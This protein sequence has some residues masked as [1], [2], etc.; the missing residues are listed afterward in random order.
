MVYIL[1]HHFIYISLP[2]V[3]AIG[4]LVLLGVVERGATIIL[5]LEELL[6]SLLVLFHLLLDLILLL[7]LVLLFRVPDHGDGPILLS[8]Q[9]STLPHLLHDHVA[10]VCLELL[11]RHGLLLG[12][13]SHQLQLLHRVLS[14]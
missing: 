12:P 5:P 11:L 4:I 2:L 14:T 6:L 9:R 1:K 3:L 8:L 7:Q 10:L 13:Q